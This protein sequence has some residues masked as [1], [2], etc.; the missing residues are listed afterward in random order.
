MD[1][2]GACLGVCYSDNHLFYSVNSP[3]K[4]S[5]VHHIGSIDFT[6][7]V[8]NAIVTGSSDE[9]P[10]LNSALESI[11]KEYNCTSVK[12]LSPASK[13]CW[14]VVPRVVYEDPSEREA[15]IQLLMHG[16]ERSDIH[17]TWH[18][19]YKSGCRLMLLRNNQSML[20]F[21]YLL[22]SFVYT[23]YVSD[24]ELAIDWQ[25]HTRNTGSFLMIHCHKRY[26][27]ATSFILGKLRGC[28]YIEFDYISDLPYLW[29]LFSDRLPWL[30]GIHDENF[31]YGHYSSEVAELLSPYWRD[32]G[33]IRFFN[34][35]D[36]VNVDADEKTYG[37]KLGSA[38]PA[39][40]MSLD[41]DIDKNKS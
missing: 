6:F 41:V 34:M 12:I 18:R 24:F 28:T 2:S 36:D 1:P 35:L 32:H 20:G 21:N 3:G 30:R 4:K 23:E 31:V 38:F 14:S 40:I 9:F 19:V 8:E 37:F 27:S 33:E 7:D 25:I 5:R 26:I 22:R 15:H 29:N 11:R 39:I 16:I 17:T 13:E 10:A